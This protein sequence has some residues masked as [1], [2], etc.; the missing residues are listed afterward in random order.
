MPFTAAGAEEGS[1]ATEDAGS[2]SS[3]ANSSRADGCIA[4]AGSQTANEPAPDPAT[5]PPAA[6]LSEGPGT[7]SGKGLSTSPLPKTQMRLPVSQSLAKL[8]LGSISKEG[9]SMAAEPAAQGQQPSAAAALSDSKMG[10]GESSKSAA[11]SVADAKAVLPEQR[12]SCSKSKRE[13]GRGK[14]KARKGG[15]SPAGEPTAMPLEKLVVRKAAARDAEHLPV[16]AADVAGVGTLPAQ[17]GPAGRGGKASLT[18]AQAATL[19]TATTGGNSRTDQ[20]TS[21]LAADAEHPSGGPLAHAE[22][23]GDPCMARRAEDKADR[24]LRLYAESLA[25]PEAD[26]SALYLYLGN[27]ADTELA[28]DILVEPSIY[29]GGI[30]ALSDWQCE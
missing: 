27:Q 1:H 5:A 16:R 17:R 14:R 25:L 12:P 19:G 30:A 28:L 13:A 9:A 23:T 8:A 10:H 11:Q 22:R 29:S 21:S 20:A 4:V 7:T 26:A 24:A 18:D 6:G 2:S 3:S 15:S